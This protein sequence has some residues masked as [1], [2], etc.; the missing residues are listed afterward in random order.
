MTFWAT[1]E[2]TLKDWFNKTNIF[3]LRVELSHGNSF[4]F[5]LRI[6]L[7]PPV[8]WRQMEVVVLT[9]LCVTLWVLT[10]FFRCRITPN[11][12][13]KFFFLLLWCSDLQVLYSK[14][15]KICMGL[16]LHGSHRPFP[17][18]FNTDALSWPSVSDI[19]TQ[20][21]HMHAQL[22][23]LSTQRTEKLWLQQDAISPLYHNIASYCLLMFWM[24]ITAS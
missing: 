18:F 20:G 22:D 23:R 2:F 21:T 5:Y 10:V 15:I 4:G 12:N 11:M 17:N 16:P 24:S 19:N 13:Q 7:L 9:A 14:W 8:H 6:L 3:R 1:S